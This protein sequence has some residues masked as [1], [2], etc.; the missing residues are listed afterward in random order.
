MQKMR[1]SNTHLRWENRK[2]K[3]LIFEIKFWKNETKTDLDCLREE[4]TFKLL[5]KN[6]RF[7]EKEVLELKIYNWNTK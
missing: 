4:I 5:N 3:K 1:I 7:S 6:G 2:E